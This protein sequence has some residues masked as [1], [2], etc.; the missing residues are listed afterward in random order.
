M[1][2]LLPKI[3]DLAPIWLQN[4][5]VTVAG[6]RNSKS[7]YGKVYF[8]HKEFLRN[9]D[10]WPLAEK[11]EYQR[12]KFIRFVRYA[13][14]N[15]RFYRELY[16]VADINNIQRIKDLQL[17]PIVDKEMLRENAD[18]VFTVPPERALEG[19][20]GGTTGKSLVV[21]LTPDDMMK[22][23]AMLDHFKERV[24]FQHLK[25]SRATFNGKHIVPPGQK[26]KVFWRYNHYCKQ[27]IYSSFHITEEN[28]GY[29]VES[30][31]RF[32]PKAL[33][34]FFTC[35][36]DIANY[37]ERH[38]IRL[39]FQ[40]LAIFPTAETLTQPGRELLE[41]VFN[42]KVYDQYASSEGAPFVTECEHQNLHVELASG[43]FENLEQGSDEVVVTSFT[44][45]GTPLI[46]YR[47]GDS[48][49][50]APPDSA[51]P[52]G[53]RSPLV[54]R[55]QGRNLDFLYT[56]EGAKVNAGNVA[57]LFKN[58]PNAL[59]RAQ[60]RQEKRGEIQVLLEV[61]R[62]VYK[63]EYDEILLGEFI[64]KFGDSTEVIIRH[65]D[66]IPRE[67]SGKFRMIKNTVDE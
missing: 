34:G 8:K 56:A 44:T 67:K 43:V 32:K 23:M 14:E 60:T 4:A 33:D 59:I 50:F 39:D 46:R 1:K 41:R 54:E 9:F 3:Y 29:Y 13:Y 42:C 27:M 11:Q 37:I 10:A 48:F 51:C 28:A 7:R 53:M 57:N 5:M 12:Q 47:I 35:M 18:R 63:S 21:L 58:M 36:V 22:R 66:E 24:G 17:L 45:H 62:K 49:R 61:D 25:M 40:P 65:V 19:H 15:S 16:R 2:L 55:I 52:C 31:N 26:K 6:Y 38:D 30:L 20:T 64:H